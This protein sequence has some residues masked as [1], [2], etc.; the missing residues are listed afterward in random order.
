MQT[1]KSL[2]RS[3]LQFKLF[4]LMLGSTAF[5]LALVGTRL[6]LSSFDLNQI[7]STQDLIRLRGA[8][9]FLFLVWNLFLAWIPYG[10]ALFLEGSYRYFQSRWI[11]GLMLISWLLFFPNAPYI[12]TDLLH[13]RSRAPIPY[14]YDLM[15]LISFAWT[16]L[17][18]GFLSL[19][20][21]QVFF[22]RRFNNWVSWSV[23]FSAIVLCAF[24]IY[25]GRFL[26][27]N[28]WDILTNPQ[29]LFQDIFLSMQLSGPLQVTLILSGFLLMGYL[30]FAT[31]INER[32]H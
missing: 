6:H 23:S 32:D 22:R 31:L 17:L 20:E 16:G 5:C 15:L 8:S 19:Y 1:I 13:L 26:R 11:I 14:W 10:I 21:V 27:W 7:Q 4:L 18:L 29:G 25:L 28:S 30:T 2:F 3:P 24:G 12:L 9:T